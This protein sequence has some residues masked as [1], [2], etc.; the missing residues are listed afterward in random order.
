MM[1]EW[2]RRLGLLTSVAAIWVLGASGVLA[3]PPAA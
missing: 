3:V 1:L 2:Q